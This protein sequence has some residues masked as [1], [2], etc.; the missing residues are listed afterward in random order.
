ML[1][2]VLLCGPVQALD[3][4]LLVGIE[5]YRDPDIAPL[6]GVGMDLQTMRA[7]AGWLGYTQVTVLRDRQAGLASLRR[8]FAQL[9]EQAG[10]RDRVLIYFSGH[11][12][13]IHDDSGDEQD[14]GRDEALALYDFRVDAQDRVRGVL[15]D[16]ELGKWIG[17]LRAGSVLVLIDAC[18]SGSA[19]KA[20]DLFA[21][22]PALQA[23]GLT[24]FDDLHLGERLSDW[25][26]DPAADGDAVVIGASADYEVAYSSPQGSVFTLAL[27]HALIDAARRG[28]TVTPALLRAEGERYIRERLPVVNRFRPQISGAKER[29]RAALPVQLPPG[30]DATLREIA[31]R[32][33]AFRVTR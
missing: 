29:R 6:A 19:T 18:H 24:W 16:D 7:V 27:A 31:R 32:S 21:K 5:H 14:D 22:G 11:G 13:R 9:R 12:I 10:P 1:A 25:W 4:A 20:G 3:R 26:R 33:A 15:V 28:Q 30:R 23:K 2:V 8:Q 17:E